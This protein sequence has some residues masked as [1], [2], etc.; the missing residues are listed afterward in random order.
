MRSDEVKTQSFTFNLY[1]KSFKNNG[2]LQRRLREHW[3]KPSLPRGSSPT[4]PV[5]GSFKHVLT[6]HRPP[7]G[8][9]RSW[10]T[11]NGTHHHHHHHLHPAPNKPRVYDQIIST[12]IITHLEARSETKTLICQIKSRGKTNLLVDLRSLFLVWEKNSGM[13]KQTRDFHPGDPSSCPGLNNTEL[14]INPHF[15][16]NLLTCYEK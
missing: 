1:L 10:E 9:R 2:F 7:A 11:E 6:D 3:T 13:L 5:V 15:S 16:E 14:I 8:R 12:S 4:G